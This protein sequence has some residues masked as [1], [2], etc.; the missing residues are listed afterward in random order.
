[1]TSAAQHTAPSQVLRWLCCGLALVAVGACD[2]SS[3]LMIVNG[4]DQIITAIFTPRGV[5][6]LEGAQLTPQTFVRIPQQV[7]RAATGDTGTP[8]PLEAYSTTGACAVHPSESGRWEL[9]SADLD[10]SGC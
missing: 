4:S 9:H 6:L 8:R 3:D 7:L 2:S 10:P 5:D 1:M